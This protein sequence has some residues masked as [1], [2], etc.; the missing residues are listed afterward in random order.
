MAKKRRFRK[1]DSRLTASLIQAM[2]QD[3][4]LKRYKYHQRNIS[5][6]QY[7][8]FLL[9]FVTEFLSKNR[10]NARFFSLTCPMPPA[11]TF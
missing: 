10:T 2:I 11:N 1:R 4:Y 8:E 5:V 7:A 3:W 9:E 6:D